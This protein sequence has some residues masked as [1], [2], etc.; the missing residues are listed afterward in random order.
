VKLR[1]WRRDVPAGPPSRD[2]VQA[3]LRELRRDKEK[4]DKYEA[5]FNKNPAEMGSLPIDPNLC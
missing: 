3:M 2:E 5:A 4:L 1:F